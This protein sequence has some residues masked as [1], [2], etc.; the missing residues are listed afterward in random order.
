MS[1]LANFQSVNNDPKSLFS[2]FC[3]CILKNPEFNADFKSIKTFT[4]NALVL[5]SG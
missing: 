5:L 1:F 3:I 2:Y 4:K